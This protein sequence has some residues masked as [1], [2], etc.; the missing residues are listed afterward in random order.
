MRRRAQVLRKNATPQENKLWY[1]YLRKYPVQWNRQ[2]P[3]GGYIVD[4]YC[5]RAGLVVELDGSQHFTSDGQAYDA[6]RTDHLEARGLT[7]LRFTN[8][9]ID[10]R[11]RQ[12]CDSIDHAVLCAL[13]GGSPDLPLGEGAPAGGG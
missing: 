3:L 10:H 1:Q 2:K 12:V 4:F 9:D 11:F 13:P 6:V 8:T 5:R 7:V